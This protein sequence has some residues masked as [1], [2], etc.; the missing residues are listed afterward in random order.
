[1]RQANHLFWFLAGGLALLAASCQPIGQNSDRLTST[2][3]TSTA[4]QPSTSAN[5]APADRIAAPSEAMPTTTAPQTAITIYEIDS[6]CSSFVPQIV[7]VDADRAMEQAVSKVLSNEQTGIGFDLAGYRVS[8]DEGSREATV[9]L[10]LSPQSQ[11][12]L[13]SL[14][15]CEQLAVFGS[16]RETL[17]N[18][19]DWNIRSVRFT[20]RGEAIAL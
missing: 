15:S 20:E 8:L 13:V 11:R 2:P 17:L 18:N 1:M 5:S 4:L 6:T 14:S 10:R 9:D 3:S 16:L 7:Q 19:S 12:Q